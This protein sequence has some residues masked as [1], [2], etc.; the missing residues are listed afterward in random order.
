MMCRAAERCI[1]VKYKETIDDVVVS[2]SFCQTYWRTSSE[3]L[4][5]Q[6]SGLSILVGPSFS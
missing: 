4:A 6:L 3:M 2:T 5:T 1:I